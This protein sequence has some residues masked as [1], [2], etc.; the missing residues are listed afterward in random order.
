MLPKI[1]VTLSWVFSYGAGRGFVTSNPVAGIRLRKT[2]RPDIGQ[3]VAPFTLPSERNLKH[4]IEAARRFDNTGRASALIG[5]MMYAGLRASEVRGL[6]WIDLQLDG[7]NPMV[8]VNQRADRYDE[9]GKVKSK[10]SKREVG[11]GPDTGMA[12]KRWLEAA[13]E[14]ELVFANEEGNPSSY[15]NLW[16]RFWVPLMNKAGLV[17]A[18]LASNTV[19]QANSAYAGF[20]QPQFGF[21]MLRHVFASI[22]IKLD[23][24]PKRLQMLMG[25]STLK[26]TMD[27]YGHLWPDAA[28]DSER[29]S[30]TERAFG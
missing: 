14:A 12:I 3:G 22:Q 29:A 24:K 10:G 13:S 28:A 21:H 26:L 5:L 17:S 27:T 19:R 4:L 11:L 15:Q 9:I 8:T 6:R 16:N 23:V 30:A 25:H 18:E 7:K 2:S 1:K 20:R